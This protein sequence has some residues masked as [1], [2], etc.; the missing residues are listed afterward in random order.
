M[1]FAVIFGVTP[2]SLLAFHRLSGGV[3]IGVMARLEKAKRWQIFC[4]K[5]DFGVI[6]NILD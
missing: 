4:K 3:D 1:I 6:A 2:N 5:N